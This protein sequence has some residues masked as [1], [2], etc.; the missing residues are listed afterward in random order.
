MELQQGLFHHLYLY[1]ISL[2]FPFEEK[3]T[4]I[5]VEPRHKKSLNY[6]VKVNLLLFKADVSCIHRGKEMKTLQKL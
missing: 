5:S 3:K 6:S 1:Y 4:L 2:Y